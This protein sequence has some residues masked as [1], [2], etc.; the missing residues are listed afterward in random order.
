MKL[1]VLGKWAEVWMRK[2]FIFAHVLD[3]GA[4]KFLLGKEGGKRHERESGWSCEW[5]WLA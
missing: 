1:T 3:V 4:G 5:A 2:S